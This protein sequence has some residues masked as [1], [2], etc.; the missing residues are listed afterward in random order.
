VKISNY[1]FEERTFFS[2]PRTPK[3][4]LDRMKQ[5]FFIQ[6]NFK[7]S[8]LKKKNCHNNRKIFSKI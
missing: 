2:G 1:L 8:E 4:P 6:F 5:I 3:I 7:E